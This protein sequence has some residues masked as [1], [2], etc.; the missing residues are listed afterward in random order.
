MS[1]LECVWLAISKS[2]ALLSWPS[3]VEEPISPISSTVHLA[4]G[5]A[6]TTYTVTAAPE[7]KV[8]PFLVAIEDPEDGGSVFG[9]GRFG[10][11]EGD[12]FFRLCL[13]Q[14]WV[15]VFHQIHHLKCSDQRF[16][17]RRSQTYGG[18]GSVFSGF[19][20]LRLPK[21]L[22][23]LRKQSSDFLFGSFRKREIF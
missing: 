7:E 1:Q 19:W 12:V 6:V 18:F 3:W 20:N 23:W 11:C 10:G 5:I 2:N 22:H 9:G 16:R 4:E 14:I 15:R 21:F 8:I 17:Q 13:E